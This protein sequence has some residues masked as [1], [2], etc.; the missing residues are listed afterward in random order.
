VIVYFDAVKFDGTKP[1]IAE[2][3]PA[4]VADGF[5]TPEKLPWNYVSKLQQG[6]D[7]EHF[8]IGG[9]YDLI[10]GGGLVRTMT[11]TTLV[12]TETDEGVGNESFIGAIGTVDKDQILPSLSLKQDYYVVRHHHDQQGA[13]ATATSKAVFAYLEEGPTRFDIQE[14]IVD[15][16]KERMLVLATAPQRTAAEHSAPYVRIKAFHLPD[17]SPRYY[18]SAEWY[19]GAQITDT[20]YSIAAWITAVPKL[21][22][23]ALEP[24]T[25]GY[26]GDE[27]E[28]LNVLDLGDGMAG[29][30]LS[31]SRGESVETDLFEYRDGVDLKRMRILQSIAFGE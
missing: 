14:Q 15:L 18:A 26:G 17:G 25:F 20:T 28:L 16:L 19:Q 2:K 30:I 8:R 5:F 27:P 7:A 24:R 13:N 23:M 1:S 3:L 12:G 29:V 31:I 21:Q 4:P 9:T 6:P 11:L 22:I 10:F